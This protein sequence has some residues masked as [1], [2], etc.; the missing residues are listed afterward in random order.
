MRSDEL[1][2]ALFQW[3]RDSVAR[4]AMHSSAMSWKYPKPW[5]NEVE[6]Y[7]ES[8][9]LGQMTIWQQ[10]L[11]EGTSREELLKRLDNLYCALS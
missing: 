6:P 5:R 2:E 11:L 4:L 7:W 10:F 9:Q 1:G 8:Y 3:H